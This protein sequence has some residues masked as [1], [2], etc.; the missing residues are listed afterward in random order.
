MP[1]N[2]PT[3]TAVVCSIGWQTLYHVNLF[4][5]DRRNESH[6]HKS[7]VLTVSLSLT[8]V[9]SDLWKKPRIVGGISGYKSEDLASGSAFTILVNLLFHEMGT[10][11]TNSSA[12]LTG[13]CKDPTRQMLYENG[14]HRPGSDQLVSDAS[15]E[16]ACL[17]LYQFTWLFILILETSRSLLRLS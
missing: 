10:L 12:F 4:F 3:K 17:V 14:L 16:T 1:H 6:I 8:T 11:I 7:F 13:Q 9:R 15:Q 5:K 2:S